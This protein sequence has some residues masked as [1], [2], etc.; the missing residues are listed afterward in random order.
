MGFGLLEPKQHSFVV[1]DENVN[2]NFLDKGD[3]SADSCLGFKNLISPSSLPPTIKS[4]LSKDQL[5][6]GEQVGEE[7]CLEP[8]SLVHI[9]RAVEGLVRSLEND[10]G[11]VVGHANENDDQSAQEQGDGMN[12]TGLAGI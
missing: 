4:K 12:A 8:E 6:I 11:M 9:G 2:P 7:S 10:L 1:L 3:G 5:R